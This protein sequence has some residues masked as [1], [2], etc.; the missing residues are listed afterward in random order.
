MAMNERGQ[1]G[2]RSTLQQT[3]DRGGLQLGAAPAASK[4]DPGAPWWVFGGFVGG[5]LLLAS[6]RIDAAYGRG[7]RDG[8][9]H[10]RGEDTRKYY[11][12]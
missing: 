12:R 3:R 1:Y 10:E 7:F 5:V 2:N 8:K 4:C 11:E 6:S 9:A